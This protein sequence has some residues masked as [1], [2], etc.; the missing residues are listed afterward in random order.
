MARIRGSYPGGP[1]RDDDAS[2]A[3]GEG[4]AA[5][6]GLRRVERIEARLGRRSRARAK[7]ERARRIWSGLAVAVAVAVGMGLYLGARSHRTSE[8]LTD[9]RNQ[10]RELE[11][12]LTR[13]TNRVLL[14]LWKM[15]EV[16]KQA[17]P[18]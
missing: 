7:R 5:T 11:Q 15:E 9:E 1:S 18:P 17:T 12:T 14:E 4:A 8:Q 10:Q 16:E 2:A 6:P 13:E 3:P